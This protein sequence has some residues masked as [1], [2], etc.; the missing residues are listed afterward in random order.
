M[1]VG[2]ALASGAYAADSARIKWD[3]NGHY[4]QLFEGA[5]ITWANAKTAC[6]GKSAHLATIT[7]EAENGFIRSQLLAGRSYWY[8]IGGTSSDT[9]KWTWITG[10]AWG[11][12]PFAADRGH[13]QHNAGQNYLVISANYSPY[14]QYPGYGGQWFNVYSSDTFTGYI[15]EWST[16]NYIDTTLVP[17]MNNNGVDEVA[18]LYVD[19]KTGKHTVQIKDPATDTVLK[20]LVFVTNFIPPSGLV[21]LHDTNDNGAAEIGVLFTQFR[22]PNVQI[23]DTK[24]SKTVRNITFLN[25]GFTPKTIGVSA[26]ADANGA[27]EIVVLGINRTSGAATAEIHDSK[28]GQVTN[29]TPF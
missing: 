28:T 21:A 4:Y 16:Q 24:T 6:E 5:P 8:S 19:L 22:Y 27:D 12:Q 25:P 11:F 26:D 18:V 9:Y 3:T 23:I 7:S 29:N 13:P 17:D 14:Q 20:T 15:C 2:L 1:I 10:E